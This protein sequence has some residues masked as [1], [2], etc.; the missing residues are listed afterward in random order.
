MKPA[1]NLPKKIL[2]F[3]LSAILEK[4]SFILSPRKK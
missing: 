2:E 3:N 1:E 4:R